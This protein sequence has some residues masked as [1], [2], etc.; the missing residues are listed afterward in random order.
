MKTD[1]EFFC[2]VLFVNF[3]SNDPNDPYELPII[4]FGSKKGN[5]RAYLW[6]LEDEEGE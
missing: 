3:L 5:I 6:P 4:F 2:H 1:G